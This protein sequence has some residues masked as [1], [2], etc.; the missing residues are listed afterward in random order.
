MLRH[1]SPQLIGA[2]ATAKATSTPA[3][4]SDATVRRVKKR[5]VSDGG[6][7]GV[8]G[9]MGASVAVTRIG[10]LLVAG[11]AQASQQRAAMWRWGT[12]RCV[13]LALRQD[14]RQLIELAVLAAVYRRPAVPLTDMK[15][16]LEAAVRHRNR[17]HLVGAR[18]DDA[19]HPSMS[20]QH[21]V[22]RDRSEE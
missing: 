1:A 18:F 2:R 3:A 15:H 22:R 8:A 5:L 14:P 20:A 11:T 6:T 21:S 13:H 19:P 7:S 17:A 10:S 12:T 4:I 9:S 16:T